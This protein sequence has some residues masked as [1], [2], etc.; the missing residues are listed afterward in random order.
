MSPRPL[1]GPRLQ[2]VLAI[3]PWVLAHPGI[4]VAELAE[5]FEVPEHELERDLAL[6]PFC[7]LPPYTAD[8]LIDVTV[9]DGEVEIRLAEYF[10]RPLRLTPAEGLALLAAG[11]ALLSV[12]GSDDHG[13]LATA[14]EKLEHVLGAKGTLA[15]DVGSTG[16][17]TALQEA[18]QE[19]TQLEIDYYSFARDEMTTRVIDPWRV[20]HAFGAWYV[21]AWCHRAGAER[22]FRV[23]RVRAVRATGVAFDPSE[24]AGSFDGDTADLVY[25]PRPDDLRV[26]LRLA[27]E[28]A[29]VVESYPHESVRERAKGQLDVVLAVS[30]P[31]WLERLLLTLGERATI[32]APREARGMAAAAATRVLAR[33]TP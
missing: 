21:A 7:G 11:R 13:P 9:I 15:V 31:A 17:L 10:E 29:W 12:P 26:T 28:A 6:L 23:D 27:P 20:F 5:R 22:L 4:T 2:R 3:V 24:H 8:R 33:Y 25:R 32:I 30:E 19:H 1:V 14:L 16:G 18:V